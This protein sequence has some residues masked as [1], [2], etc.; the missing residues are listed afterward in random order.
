MFMGKDLI[1]C[2][3]N[4]FPSDIDI[5]FVRLNLKNI[6]SNNTYVYENI[7]ECCDPFDE[8]CEGVDDLVETLIYYINELLSGGFDRNLA[9]IPTF[10]SDGSRINLLLAG[11]E[12]WGDSCEAYDAVY[13]LSYLPD[14][15]WLPNKAKIL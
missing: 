15:W 12:S 10:D 8:N 2:W 6:L 11:Y 7:K 1:T 3:I 14:D 13:A 5:D 9:L 4:N